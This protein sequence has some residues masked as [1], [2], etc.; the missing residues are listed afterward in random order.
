[1]RENAS[2]TDGEIIFG[3]CDATF[4]D[5]LCLVRQPGLASLLHGLGQ[6]KCSIADAS[7]SSPGE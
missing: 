6:L 2:P 3:N 7:A 4:N 1:M 5:D